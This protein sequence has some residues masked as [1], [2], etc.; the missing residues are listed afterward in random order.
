MKK[1]VRSLLWISSICYLTSCSIPEAHVELPT[2][3]RSNMVLQRDV[4]VHLWG[5]C[6][7]E[8]KI[9]VQFQKHTFR[10]RTD[11]NG[12]WDITLDSYPAGGPY[13]L[14][15]NRDTLKNVF[16]GD[17]WVCSGQSNM[18]WPLLES[19]SAEATLKRK[20]NPRVR[21]FQVKNTVSQTELED[22]PTH[23]A[24]QESLPESIAGFS[25]IGYLFGRELAKTL[26]V[27]IGIISADWGGSPIEVWM[28]KDILNDEERA[29]QPQRDS[30]FNAYQEELKIWNQKVDRADSLY[31]GS[32]NIHSQY[33]QDIEWDTIMMPDYWEKTLY[34]DFDGIVYLRKEFV[35]DRYPS[36]GSIM[37][38]CVDDIDEVYINGKK[39]GSGE[40]FNNVR[41]YTIPKGVL[42]NGLNI[43]VVRIKDNG[44]NGGI[45]PLNGLMFLTYNEKKMSLEGEWKCKA[46]L[47]LK[48]MPEKPKG[49]M[50]ENTYLYNA[51]LAPLTKLPIKGVIWYQGESNVWDAGNYEEKF[52]RMVADWRQKWKLGNFPFLYVQLANF[53]VDGEGDTQWAELREAQ[54]KSLNIPN[55]GMAVTID[56]GEEDNIH[57]VN[58]IDVAKR[59]RLA[60]QRIAYGQDI[61]S[62]GP[63]YEKYQTNGNQI[64]VSFSSIGTGLKSSDGEPLRNFEISDQN[65]NWY[66]AQATIKGDVVV[67]SSPQVTQPSGVRYAW[68]SAPRNVNFYNVE[69]LPASPFTSK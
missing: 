68:E 19:S 29:K 56:I 40:G 30:A 66:P 55:T 57:P 21:L 26:N 28:S 39:I 52:T 58:K 59:L 22:A 23:F 12:N 45:R 54:R 15:I 17:V 34:P 64:L 65:G 67:V 1:L 20:G 53:K 16:V 61:V 10:T 14:I 7:P 31:I 41:G 6:T 4:P 11:E 60:A 51:M 47:P 35:L 8:E 3:L 5:K 48:N 13:N 43:L 49:S 25:A 42:M 2:L 18:E 9:A 24:W 33:I 27:P 32:T 37:L 46:S 63:L 50:W 44:G 36:Y 62:S 38:G 69:G